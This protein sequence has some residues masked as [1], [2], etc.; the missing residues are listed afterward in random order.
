MKRES[1]Y[2]LMSRGSILASRIP[3]AFPFLI[4]IGQT[5]RSLTASPRA[6][7]LPLHSTCDSDAPA[8]SPEGSRHDGL[9]FASRTGPI[10]ASASASTS[11]CRDR[12]PY[13]LGRENALTSYT[14]GGSPVPKSGSL[15]SVRGAGSNACPY[16]ENAE[17]ASKSLMR[18]PTWL[19]YRE[20]CHR[21]GSERT[22][23]PVV[24]PG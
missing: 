13:I 24:P 7:A 20:G 1:T 5:P 17:Q 22:K 3:F 18:K 23:H 12:V 14:Q 10:L 16:R 21:W 6:E 4:Q 8:G 2:N 11:G 9:I 19:S 15:G